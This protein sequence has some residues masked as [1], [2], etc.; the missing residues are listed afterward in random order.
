MT[1]T[2]WLRVH[3]SSKCLLSA[4]ALPG[5]IEKHREYPLL[6]LC[7][8]CTYDQVSRVTQRKGWALPAPAVAEPSGAEATRE[9]GPGTRWLVT[10]RG[11]QILSERRALRFQ[12]GRS[13]RCCCS[14]TCSCVRA[15]PP[16]PSVPAGRS[17][18]RCR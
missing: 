9:G 10:A 15:W 2:P 4:E 14:Q 6:K 11:A 7:Y 16:C 12:Q 8:E 1:S 3:L 13:C 17:T 18:A 5:A